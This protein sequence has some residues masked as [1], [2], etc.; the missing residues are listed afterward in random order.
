MIVQ[1]LLFIYLQIDTNMITTR[2]IVL[3][4]V[5][6]NFEFA[7]A[8]NNVAPIKDSLHSKSFAYLSN[9]VI[10]NSSDSLRSRIYLNAWLKSAKTQSNQ[11]QMANAYRILSHKSASSYKITYADSMLWS[12]KKT[13]DDLLIGTAYLTKGIAYYASKEL[14]KSLD[15]YLLADKYVSKTKD[16][17][18]KYMVKYTIALTKHHIGFYD[19]AI[20]LFND[21]LDYY[22]TE[23]DRAY[24]NTL[25][26]LGMCYNKIGKFEKA[27]QIYIQGR[28][29]CKEFANTDM[30]PY[31]IN[32]EGINQFSKK[33]YKTA[34][35]LLFKSMP[36]LKAKKDFAN[37][38]IT[39]FYIGKSYLELQ[40]MA[41]ALPY[42]M[43]VDSIFQYKKYIRID[44]RE[45]Y[46]LLIDY[47]KSK[48]DVNAQ[49]RYVNTLLKVDKELN[50][51]H[52]YLLEKV[53]KEYDTVKLLAVKSE[54]EDSL[55]T[56]NDNKSIIIGSMLVTVVA[57][58]IRSYKIRK[59]YHR[60]FRELMAKKEVND[61]PEPVSMK[62]AIAEI[63]P[64]VI[65]TVVKKMRT[66]ERKKEFLQKELTQVKLAAILETNT[67]YIPK[68]VL[69][70]TGKTTID[71]ICDLKIDYLIELLKTDSRVRNYTHK[72]LGQEV[73]FGSTQ[74]FTRA[75]KSRTGLTPSFFIS[76]LKKTLKESEG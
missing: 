63:S 21:C 24:L 46:E 37:E 33:K 72:A 13:K 28:N 7:V 55:R 61:K 31:F 15:N 12:A 34:L 11:K 2:F 76:E 51:N 45:N 67:R 69:H 70:E 30:L 40:Q 64:E 74:N 59:K 18:A 5:V 38:S 41:K 49:L 48:K 57:I 19:E 60:K 16:E 47:Y 43:K 14:R 71:Y 58:V 54:I 29:A 6:L 8:Q 53:I 35:Q 1:L 23:N 50:L 22:S 62:E 42:F 9:A 44:L 25:H 10:S 4:L 68:I 20:A 75:F 32:A 66:F 39:S 26:S 17:D 52:N 56:K 65:A 73:G 27:S 36:H 3:V